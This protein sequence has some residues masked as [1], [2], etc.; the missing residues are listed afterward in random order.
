[1]ES[2]SAQLLSLRKGTGIMKMKNNQLKKLAVALITL[3]L[4]AVVLLNSTSVR[5]R[6]ASGDVDVAALYKDNKCGVCHG[7]KAAKF[8]D[9]T[10]PDDQLIEIVMKG[11]K[12][13]KP[14]NMPGYEE[15]GLTA[16]QAKALV[17]YMKQL[18]GAGGQ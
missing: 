11:K 1:M 12:A 8:F 10:K 7:P 14:P 16:D 2:L 4:L 13:E 6:A 18:A 9:A 5:T 15:K 3:P 17:A